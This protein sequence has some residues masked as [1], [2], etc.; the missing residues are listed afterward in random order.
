MAMTM[1]SIYTKMK[2]DGYVIVP[3]LNSW[4]EQ[5]KDKIWSNYYPS[6]ALTPVD[7]WRRYI[8]PDNTKDTDFSI[9][10][11]RFHDRGYRVKKATLEIH[12][13]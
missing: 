2:V 13:D 7:A 6:F 4:D 5:H 9:V 11:Q 8:H 3:P 12:D 10:V 1:L